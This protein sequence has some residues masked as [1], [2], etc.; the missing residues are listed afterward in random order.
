MGHLKTPVS[1]QCFWW[2]YWPGIRSPLVLLS[3]PL[4][5]PVSTLVSVPSCFAAFIF[6]S[7]T[8]LHLSSP[9]ILDLRCFP[10]RPPLLSLLSSPISWSLGGSSCS[11]QEAHLTLQRDYLPQDN[12]NTHSDNPS[13]HTLNQPLLRTNVTFSFNNLR[14]RSFGVKHY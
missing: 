14:A 13:K 1:S 6:Y 5:A 7:L 3:S 11:H 9:F 12:Y 2:E 8:L 10:P 4:S